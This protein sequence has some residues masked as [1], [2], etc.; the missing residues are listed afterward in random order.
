MDPLPL[1]FPQDK[2]LTLNLPTAPGD[3]THIP[4]SAQ[5]IYEILSAE[6]ARVKA[7]APPA[8]KPHVLDTEKRLAILF[9]HL[10]N[11]DLIKPDTVQELVALARAISGKQ[12]EQAQAMFMD[13]MTRKNDEGS[14]WMVSCGFFCT[15]VQRCGDS[16]C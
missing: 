10:N 9:D 13:L 11:E 16:K 5:P 6:I 14:N 15:T 8:Y 4:A 1:N 2:T 7:K 12:Y 3:R